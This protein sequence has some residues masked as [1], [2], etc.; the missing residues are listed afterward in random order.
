MDLSAYLRERYLS[1][2]WLY[3][4]TVAFF[5]A[6]TPILTVYYDLIT[7]AGVQALGFAVVSLLGFSVTAVALR[8]YW[9][10]TRRESAELP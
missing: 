1:K 3:V 9:Q 6:V 2:V 5:I 4:A 8:Q 10:H 7:P